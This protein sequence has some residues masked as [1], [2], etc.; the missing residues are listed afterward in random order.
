[1]ILLACD[2]GG[3]RMKAAVV[4]GGGIRART[5][6]PAQSDRPMRECL[7]SLAAAFR[8]L[9]G[10]AGVRVSDCAG[11]CLSFPSLVDNASGRVLAEYG[12]YRDAPGTD[13]RAWADAKFGLPLAIENDARMALVG[14]W[15]HGA[16]RGRD[17]L[18]MIT[19]GTGL[20]VAALMEGR[21]IRGRHGQAAVLGGHTTVRYG[22]RRCS[23]GNI[24]CAETE[25]AGACLREI[26]AGQP[27]FAA[28]GLQAEPAPDYAVVF[29]HA[30]N[31]DACAKAIV[32][33]SARVWGVLAVNMIHTFDPERVIM[34][35]GIMAAADQILPAIRDH[36]SRHAHTPWGK[37]D[38]VPSELGDAAA[39]MAAEWLMEEHL[40]LHR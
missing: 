24:G 31:G 6:I 11:I 9:V 13:L 14:E 17:D 12:K 22:G 15:R 35:G 38:V 16:G 21:L 32:D 23:C 3:T 5:V 36:V 1:M 33:H 4:A 10:E 37:V 26:A 7:A 29:R 28:S 39:L 30:R 27:G 2:M 40:R 18:V 20:G 19:L 25:A 34:G 8:R